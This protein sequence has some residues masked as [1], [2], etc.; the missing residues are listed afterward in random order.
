MN[1]RIII[2]SFIAALAVSGCKKYLDKEPDNRTQIKTPDQIAQLLTTAYPKENYILFTESMSDN[3]EDKQGGGSGYDNIDRINRQSYRFEVVEVSPDDEDGPDNYWTGCYKAIAAA[4]L[5]LE[6][7]NAFGDPAQVSAHRGEALLARAYAHFMLVTLFSK[8][9]DPATAANDPGIPY[10]TEPE[11]VTFKTYERK[12]VAFVYEMIEKDLLEGLPLINDAIYGQAPRF[13]FN[14]RAAS[15]FAARFYLF[16]REYDKVV[17]YATQALGNAVTDNL[18]PW[19]SMLTE[20]QYAEL[21]AEYTKSTTPGNLLL[22]ETNSIW[23]RS[24][25]S[26]RY[27]LGNNVAN[28]LFFRPNV[29]GNFYAYDVYGASPLFY[30]IPKF[31]EHFVTENINANS[32]TPYNTIPLITGEEALL[33]RAEAYLRLG[34]PNAAVND[35]NVF[36]S[37]NI[38]DYNPSTDKVTG[39]KCANFYGTSSSTGIFLAILDFKRAFFMHEGMRWFDIIRLGIPVLHTTDEGEQIYLA[40][41]DNRRVLQLPALTKQAGLEP[42]PR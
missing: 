14:K 38:D 25:A 28:A 17:T 29:T 15:A 7:I 41:D 8:V 26:M 16:K 22:Q 31:Y 11:K 9:Y 10:V 6:Y 2:I 42:N 32:G 23:G 18:R 36:V 30:N 19:N 5:A 1:K 12:T 24:Y 21:Q 3:A 40:P 33:N 20:L 39:S 34:N 27:G 4:N 37:Q 35:L 13:H